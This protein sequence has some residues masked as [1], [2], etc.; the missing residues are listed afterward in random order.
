MSVHSPRGVH[1][2]PHPACECGDEVSLIGNC[3][4]FAVVPVGQ[5]EDFYRGYALV[6]VPAIAI[7]AVAYLALELLS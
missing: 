7:A 4:G 5:V 3:Y 2:A 1:R 6:A